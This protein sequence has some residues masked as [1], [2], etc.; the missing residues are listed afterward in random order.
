MAKSIRVNPKK[1]R[2]RPVTT[3]KG[4]L[5]GVRILDDP[6]AAL[7]GWIAKQNEPD[8]TRPEAIRRIVEV[9]LAG[10]RAPKKLKRSPANPHAAFEFL[11]KAEQFFGG[12]KLIPERHPM[13][14]AKYFLFCHAI[15]VAL[16]AFLIKT[17]DSVDD[18]KSK[19]GH[20]L[21]RLLRS[22]RKRGLAITD[23]DVDWLSSLGEPHKRYWARSPKED[24]SQGGIPTIPQFEAEGLKLLDAVA[25]AVNGAPMIR[26]WE[27][28]DRS[29]QPARLVAWGG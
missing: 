2:G 3:G 24:W 25:T 29:G 28:R 15:E 16:K 26:S 8:L 7:D 4:T 17:G 23:R 9:G 27:L 14:F 1:K 19:Y 21:V 13:D 12:Y 20:D 22:C 11:Q 6:L 5:I 18:V 10:R